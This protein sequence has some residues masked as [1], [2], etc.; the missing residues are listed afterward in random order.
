[1]FNKFSHQIITSKS[2]LFP[3]RE[4]RIFQFLRD[5]PVGVLSMVTPENA[6][7]GSVI[8][9]ALGQDQ[10]IGFIT[11]R[12]TRK[13]R[14]LSSDNQVMLTCFEATTQTTVN[15]LG[16]A[17]ETRDAFEVNAIA[18][19]VMGASLKTTKAGIPPI[20]KLKAGAFTAFK[21]TPTSLHMA[22]YGRSER[23]GHG[24]LLQSV[25]SFELQNVSSA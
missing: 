19:A 11:K 17:K 8:Y 1:M 6:P 16:H 24:D 4:A 25:E 2:A 12:L 20:S 21:I 13:Y 9:F 18:G 22:V 14:N 3:E 10:T 15:I 23:G 5:H 7:H